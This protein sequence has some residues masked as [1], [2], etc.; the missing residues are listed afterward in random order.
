MAGK[1]HAISARGSIAG[2]PLG[3]LIG[4][5][6]LISDSIRIHCSFVSIIL[7]MSHIQHLMSI[8]ILR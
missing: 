8:F 5:N 6:A 2:R 4:V 1:V 7:I 3:S